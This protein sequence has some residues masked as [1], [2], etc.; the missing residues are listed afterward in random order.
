MLRYSIEKLKK[1]SA[2]KTEIAAIDLGADR[3]FRLR[4]YG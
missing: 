4:A 1:E 3:G 2:C